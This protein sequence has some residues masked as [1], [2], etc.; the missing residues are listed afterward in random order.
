MLL[1]FQEI[2]LWGLGI[3][4]I[5]SVIYRIFTDP[6][7]VRQIKKDME[8][9]KK[10]S[11]EAQK[12]KD[13][14]KANEHMSEMMKLSQK[15]MKLN[16]K[17]MFISLAV[18]MILLGFMHTAYSGSTVEF[19]E[20][21]DSYA[22]GEFTFDGLDYGVK[23]EKTDDGMRTFI[24]IDNDGDFAD[25]TAYSNGEVVE[26]GGSKWSIQAS[27]DLQS[28]R[29]DLVVELPFMIP[30]IAWTHLN[31]LF[32]YVLVTIPATWIFRKMLGVE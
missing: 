19:E 9:L 7:K 4:L 23:S 24:D 30:V 18:V 22:T 26:L 6:G 32:W 1:P 25:D 5:L 17:P 13:T 3:S 29:M 11:K 10:K 27:E 31:W 12:K 28:T 2:F 14:K 8:F 16:M 20:P 21:G 15:Q